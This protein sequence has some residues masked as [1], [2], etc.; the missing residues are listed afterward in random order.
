MR[1]ASVV[2]LLYGAFLVAGACLAISISGW[3]RSKTA[4][5]SSGG[6]A[7]LMAAAAFLA[8]SSKPGLSKFGV[9]GGI[10]LTLVFAATFFWRL[11]LNWAKPSEAEWL[12]ANP[13]AA[14]QTAAVESPLQNWLFPC[15]IA[16]SLIAC[17][18]LL[19]MATGKR[20][21]S[22]G[23]SDSSGWSDSGDADL[24]GGSHRKHGEDDVDGDGGDGGG[25]GGGGG[26]D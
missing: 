17:V 8:N 26:G 7:A 1:K 4:L 16:G 12:A 24:R 23:S 2:M 22:S 25:D 14:L 11:T 13:G 20:R 15:F 3:D 10:G 6:A 18:A 5:F 9:Y 19:A 21:G